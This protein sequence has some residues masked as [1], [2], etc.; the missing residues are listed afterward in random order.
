MPLFFIDAEFED[1]TRTLISLAIVSE[2]GQREFYEVLPSS[3]VQEQWV[4]E[5]VIPILQK[6]PIT[7]EQFQA[8]LETFMHQFPG[9]T[10]Y[11][12]HINDIAYFSRAL[13]KGMG[14]RI[15]IQPLIMIVD[16]ELSAKKSKILH[17]ALFDARAIR[18]SFLQR[19]GLA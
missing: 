6:A 17:N 2:D 13:D 15:R 8:K 3:Q 10:I 12:D 7:Y 5:N 16:D 11:A 19:E 9:M 4:R 1:S 14:K 18:D